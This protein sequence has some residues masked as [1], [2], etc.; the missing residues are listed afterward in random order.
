MAEIQ[1]DSKVD[2]C[3]SFTWRIGNKK[4]QQPFSLTTSEPTLDSETTIVLPH[5]YKKMNKK[6]PQQK[7]E[8]LFCDDLYLTWNYHLSFNKNMQWTERY[9]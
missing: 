9:F 1:T 8:H 4:K 2:F 7:K 6:K 5:V 3:I